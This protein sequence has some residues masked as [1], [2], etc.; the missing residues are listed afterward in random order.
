MP[1]E[2]SFTLSEMEVTNTA[3]VSILIGYELP[4]GYTGSEISVLN[5]QDLSYWFDIIQEGNFIRLQSKPT[6]LSNFFDHRITTGISGVSSTGE[7]KLRQYPLPV[8]LQQDL[9]AT[10]GDNLSL[11]DFR[12]TS[13]SPGSV[14]IEVVTYVHD[15][16]TG[17]D[18][19]EIID[20]LTLIVNFSGDFVIQRLFQVSDYLKTL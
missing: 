17:F 16:D 9:K 10:L 11:F 15:T 5:P 4:E 3:P 8:L 18:Q 19:E 12:V 2:F 13:N 20:T 7:S 6:F 14:E 1:E